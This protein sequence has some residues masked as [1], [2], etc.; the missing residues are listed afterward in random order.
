MTELTTQPADVAART[1]VETATGETL[2]VEAG[3]G[4]GKTTA[5]V[6]RI[7][8]LV[9]E[10]VPITSIAAITFTEKAA[11]ELSEKV[12]R[13]LEEAAEANKGVAGDVFRQ[14]IRD[15]DQAAIQTLHSFAM[16]ILS[17]YPLE[18]GLPPQ[19]RLRDTVEAT[20]A[21]RE[22]WQRFQDELLNSPD[23]ERVLLRGLTVGLRLNDLREV[24]ETF[25]DNWERLETVRLP[26]CDEPELV[27]ARVLGPICE[28]VALRKATASDSLTDKLDNLAGFTEFLSGI[29]TDLRRANSAM[30]RES[31]ELDLLRLLHRVEKLTKAKYPA[32]MLG[33]AKNWD[34]ALVR[35]LMKDAETA[36]W[37]MLDGTRAACICTLL[38]HLR[39]F[40]MRGA[41]E[42][43]GKGELE[44]HDLLVLA[45]NLLRDDA[46]VRA[47]LHRKFS[48][49]LIDEFQ[50]TDPIQ[51]EL[52]ALLA[53]KDGVAAEQ[54]SLAITD[55]GRLFFVGDPKQSIYR[56]RR[57]DIE[58]FKR[59]RSAFGSRHVALSANF[60]CRPGI[61]EW[62]NTVCGELFSGFGAAVDGRQADWI[63]LGAGREAARGATVHFL[64]GARTGDKD[65]GAAQVRKE[66]ADAIVATIQKARNENWL[67]RDGKKGAITRYSDIAILLPTRTNS[68]A[69]EAALGAAG[70]PV[71]VESR[72]LL[73]AAQE[74]RD[75][76]NILAAIDDPTDDVSVVAALRS[77][78]FAVD[79]GDLL[80]HVNAG[81]R[82]DYTRPAPDQSP[83]PVRSGMAALAGFH[84]ARWHASIGALV[85]KVIAERK[86]LELAVAGSRPRESWRRLRFVSEQARL[87]G[88][89]G[90]VNSLRQFVHWLRTQAAEGARIAEA[91]ANEPDDDAV[92]LL[93]I[94]AAKGLEFPIVILAGLGVPPRNWPPKI[95]WYLDEAGRENVAVRSGR[96]DT[97]FETPNYLATQDHERAHGWLERD[98]L[99]Y[100]AATRA[101]ER[102]VVSLFH[103]QLGS[104]HLKRHLDRKCSVAECLEAQREGSWD[105]LQLPMSIGPGQTATT[106]IED[107]LEAREA[108]LAE[109]A[110]RLARLAKA[111]VV[112]ATALAHDPEPSGVDAEPEPERDDLPWKKGR[113]GTSVGR[114]VHAVMQTIDLAS[115]AG[116]TETASSQAI[117]EGIADEAEHIARLAGNARLSAP[118]QAALASGKV[119]REMYVGGE[120]EGILVEG[121]IDMLYESPDGL[122]IVD[123]KTDSARDI[124]SIE[125]AMERYRLQGAAYALVLEKAIGRPVAGCVFVFTEPRIDVRVEDLEGAKA[126]VLHLLRQLLTPQAAALQG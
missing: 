34:T 67:G 21:F 117:A 53:G 113:A 78:A 91:V 9:R 52:A 89:N 126:E 63:A 41:E 118:V 79:D 28:V 54:W 1:L 61:I 17:L 20:L 64:G 44:F 37:E 31:I 23:L 15:L 108:W 86:M 40:V 11:S 2:F 57:A 59:A 96:S 25:N 125:R 56:F 62:V 122:V 51:V 124:A 36:R 66:E 32:R 29:E 10:G 102:L 90:T 114:A 81:G 88:D 119:W 101:R 6:S 68:P 95:A 76:T 83:E 35:D 58:L 94:H 120:I 30:E 111:K 92:R 27:P 93:T 80:G 74:I 77:L 107:T 46:E 65:Y 16:R 12:R 42:R 104:D 5:L 110:E 38:P 14:A 18:A 55:P 98:R 71:R 60:R 7:V 97:Y 8:S 85:E 33:N 39:D 115:G 75:L 123:Y 106:T 121:F 3:A 43:R 100:V 70:I 22:R 50:D 13:R 112:A 105:V 109:R 84:E 45:R 103:K 69:I 72:S 73:F 26:V 19:L 87:L 49:I 99:F 4:T 48:R 82:W 47:A 116:L 24:A